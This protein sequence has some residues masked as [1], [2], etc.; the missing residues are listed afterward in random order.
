VDVSSRVFRHLFT[1]DRTVFSTPH[2]LKVVGDGYPSY[3]VDDGGSLIPTVEE[4]SV[5]QEESLHLNFDGN[6]LSMVIEQAKVQK[7]RE[8][9]L[10]L[11]YNRETMT[12]SKEP[13]ASEGAQV[14]TVMGKQTGKTKC[15]TRLKGDKRRTGKKMQ[16][17]TRIVSS[18]KDGIVCHKRLD[19]KVLEEKEEMMHPMH[20]DQLEP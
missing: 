8:V 3:Q 2:A 17:P 6:M 1:D 11:S 16:E 15:E 20:V 4:A 7:E 9:Q 19:E 5:E 13:G 14:Y 12:D 10:Y 18:S